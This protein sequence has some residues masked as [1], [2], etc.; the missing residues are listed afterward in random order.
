MTIMSRKMLSS[1]LLCERHGWAAERTGEA[2]DPAG[3]E[4][5]CSQHWCWNREDEGK[6]GDYERKVWNKYGG[7]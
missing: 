6:R 2:G 7:K 5:K 3:E 1:P 4:E